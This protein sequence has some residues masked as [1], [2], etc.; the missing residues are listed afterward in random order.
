M[1]LVR[2]NNVTI[3]VHVRCHAVTIFLA[4]NIGF[5]SV[6]EVSLHFSNVAEVDLAKV[7]FPY[8]LRCIISIS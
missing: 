4:S 1:G 3:T 2:G 8:A 5:S 7:K 6:A